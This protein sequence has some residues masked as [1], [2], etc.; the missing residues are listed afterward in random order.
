MKSNNYS[1]LFA[2]VSVWY[3]VR[4]PVMSETS[5]HLRCLILNWSHNTTNIQGLAGSAQ[6]DIIHRLLSERTNYVQFRSLSS[7]LDRLFVL[8]FAVH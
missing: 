1:L 8:L 2:V 3:E 6:L 4:L 5:K 7:F